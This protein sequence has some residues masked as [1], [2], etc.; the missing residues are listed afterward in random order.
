MF[1]EQVL[2]Q[3]RKYSKFDNQTFFNLG[4]KGKRLI[5]NAVGTK[6]YNTL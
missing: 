5:I 6:C 1:N 4:P 3:L 2:S